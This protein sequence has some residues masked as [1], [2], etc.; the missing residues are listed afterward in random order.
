MNI[1][2]VMFDKGLMRTLAQEAGIERRPCSHAL[3]CVVSFL[4]VCLD[5][6]VHWP[7]IKAVN[8]IAGL[9]RLAF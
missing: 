2:D 4:S 8:I 5:L 7:I 9:G 1:E 6:A 3:G